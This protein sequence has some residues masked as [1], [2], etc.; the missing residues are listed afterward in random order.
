MMWL[1][2]RCSPCGAD[3]GGATFFDVQMPSSKS[4]PDTC[5]PSHRG[6]ARD[7]PTD[8]LSDPGPTTSTPV[9]F[10]GVRHHHHRWRPPTAPN[11]ERPRSLLEARPFIVTPVI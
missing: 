9:A 7:R 8:D 10:R 4:L 11:A 6:A 2:T 1:R 3:P 5:A